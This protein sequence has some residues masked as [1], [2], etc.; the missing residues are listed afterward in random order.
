MKS[1]RDTL[2]LVKKPLIVSMFYGTSR[3]D[4]GLTKCDVLA[5]I[6][7]AVSGSL[8]LLSNLCFRCLQ[9]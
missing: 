2:F 3:V 8:T 9:K 5:H 1:T 7:I 6:T 4:I